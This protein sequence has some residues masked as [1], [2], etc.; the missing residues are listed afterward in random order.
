MR[1]FLTPLLALLAFASA[2][3]ATEIEAT[4]AVGTFPFTIGYALRDLVLTDEPD[5]RLEAGLSNRAVLA[6]LR[7]GLDLGPV[8]RAS[9][10]AR[11]AYVYGSG[12]RLGLDGRGTVGPVA[13]EL[14]AGLW[15]AP[16]AA[17][18]PLVPYNADP[19]QL[20][21]SGYSAAV[22]G[23]YRLSRTLVLSLEPR[24]AS[25]GSQLAARLEARLPE[26]TLSG[27]PLLAFGRDGVVYGLA[28]GGRFTPE[29][30]PFRLGL[31]AFL[32]AGPGGFAYGL[33]GSAEFDLPEELGTVSAYAAY[34]P[35]RLAL[36]FAP[37]R[38]GLGLEVA[39]GPGT[40]FL[41]AQGGAASGPFGFGA[42]LGYRLVL[43]DLG[44]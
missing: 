35:W 18:D 4:A 40:A 43:E 2:A 19:D 25:D 28:L 9:A 1:R 5:L 32:G 37:L 34:E 6:G 27:G 23:A 22:S 26:L 41:R 21:P 38:L 44:G 29:E 7:A 39:A 11:L 3:R 14:R 10:G 17:Q 42:Q 24:L 15:T 13:L 33:A 30:A 8:G 36:A 31:N 20:S 16:L 12:I